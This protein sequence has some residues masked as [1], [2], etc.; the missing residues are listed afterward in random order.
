MYVGIG[1]IFLKPMKNFSLCQKRARQV[2]QRIIPLT[3]AMTPVMCQMVSEQDNI[4]LALN[5][6][7]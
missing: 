4:V 2:C 3:M 6:Y 5:R 1:K 7:L